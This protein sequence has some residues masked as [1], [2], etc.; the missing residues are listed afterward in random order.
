MNLSRKVV[1]DD[2]VP[3]ST[4]LGDSWICLNGLWL[5]SEYR[6]DGSTVDA[7]ENLDRSMG[8]SR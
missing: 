1:E 6:G 7:G 2:G 5:D 8:M 3:A 4:S